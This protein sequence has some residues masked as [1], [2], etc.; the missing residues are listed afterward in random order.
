M[1]E[2]SIWTKLLL[3]PFKVWRK[4]GCVVQAT[5]RELNFHL[6]SDQE[7]CRPSVLEQSICVGTDFG[8]LQQAKQFLS[9]HGVV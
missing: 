3:G 1:S 4:I 6:L 9:V 2:E 5:L 8:I 7:G